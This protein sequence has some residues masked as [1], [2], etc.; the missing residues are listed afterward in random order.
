MNKI[1]EQIVKNRPELSKASVST[2]SSILKSLFLKDGGDKDD[3]SLEWFNNQ[4]KIIDLLKDIEST[5]RKTILSALVVINQGNDN[6]KYKKLMMDDG[7]E[8][9][10]IINSQTMTT[11]Q[12][13]NWITQEQIKNKY[14]ELYSDIKTYLVKKDNL[15]MAEFQ[16]F[17]NLIILSLASGLYFPPRRAMDLVFLKLKDVDSEKDNFLD[18]KKKRLVWNKYKT[19]KFYGTQ[20][21]DNLPTEFL[22]LMKKFIKFNNYDYMLVDTNGD[23]LSSVKLNQRINK[24]FDNKKVGVNIFRHSF[25]SEKYKDVPALDDILKTA[26]GM[27]HSVVEALQYV[28]KPKKTKNEV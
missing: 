12:S 13:E 11:K 8:A 16:K 4:D 7:K 1:K 5:K 18:M 26:D 28:K 6:D 24:I 23:Q 19:A 17:Q 22:A 20:Y 21:S 14:K 15:S 3:I 27:G 25:L 2:Y 10:K 9:D